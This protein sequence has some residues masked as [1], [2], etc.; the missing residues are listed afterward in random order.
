M[1]LMGVVM[2][3][4]PITVVSLLLLVLVAVF[5]SGLKQAERYSFVALGCASLLV[6]AVLFAFG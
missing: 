5:R 6:F 3:S 4:L 2:L 1:N